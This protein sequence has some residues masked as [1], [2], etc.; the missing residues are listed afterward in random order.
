MKTI[1]IEKAVAMIPDGAR[2]M[3]GSFM[4]VGTPERL[5]DELVHQGRR[6][7]T[8]IANDTAM[9]GKGIGKLIPA[10]AVRKAIRHH[11]A[12]RLAG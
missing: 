6:D 5:I 12:G 8:V 11:H 3:I 1:A 2:V 7:L 4:G 9:A 10:G